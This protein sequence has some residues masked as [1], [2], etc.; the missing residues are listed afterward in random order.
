MLAPER[1][2]KAQNLGRSSGL[3]TI[4]SP[5]S[6]STQ[7]RR[8]ATG[9]VKGRMKK[10]LTDSKLP[11]TSRTPRE[12]KLRQHCR[13]VIETPVLFQPVNRRKGVKTSQRFRSRGLPPKWR[14]S[15]SAELGSARSTLDNM[16]VCALRDF[17]SLTRLDN[18]RFLLNL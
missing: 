6:P 7:K 4:T 9:D 16:S 14:R 3:S 11:R 15:V 12:H 17:R 10:S 18:D 1:Y 5:V 2:R 13:K 8:S